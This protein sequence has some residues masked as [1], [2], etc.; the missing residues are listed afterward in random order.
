MNL[1]GVAPAQGD[2][3]LS[4]ALQ[5]WKFE[6]GTS[7][8]VRISLGLNGLRA[9]RP[10]VARKQAAMQLA[11]VAGEQFQCLR[12]FER[13][14][15]IH[16]RPEDANRVARFFQARRA[17]GFEQTSK[18]SGTLWPNCK[19]Q[20]IAGDSSGVNPRSTRLNRK[21]VDQKT[22]FKIVRAIQ[23]QRKPG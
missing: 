2:V 1:H 3:R 8:T 20:A 4:L 19:G 9:A 7:A 22:R 5:I 17:A 23:D 10:D 15:Q 21:I 14:D 11:F 6:R 12:R 13:C 18:T 16:D